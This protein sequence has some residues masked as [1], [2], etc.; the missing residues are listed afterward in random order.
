MK[1]LEEEGLRF[2]ARK[3]ENGTSKLKKYMD[4]QLQK[5]KEDIEFK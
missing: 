4:R 5:E 1:Q 3:K 2:G